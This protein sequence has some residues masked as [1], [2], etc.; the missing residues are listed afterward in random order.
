[1]AV[2]SEV[3]VDWLACCGRENEAPKLVKGGIDSIKKLQDLK[4]DQFRKMGIRLSIVAYV[5]RMGEELSQKVSVSMS[6]HFVNV[7]K[8]IL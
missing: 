4:K 2:N 6:V 5:T 7:T 8:N 1:M 3:V